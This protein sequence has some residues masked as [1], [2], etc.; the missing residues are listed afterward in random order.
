M[1]RSLELPELE[2]SIDLHHE[3]IGGR[4]LQNAIGDARDRIGRDRKSVRRIRIGRVIMIGVL[5]GIERRV[6][7]LDV[8]KKSVRS[9]D[10]DARAIEDLAVSLVFVE[11]KIQPIPQV[12]PR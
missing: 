1:E 7:K 2:I 3:R 11:T 9:R 12:H 8:G 10:I 6:R 4:S 5:A